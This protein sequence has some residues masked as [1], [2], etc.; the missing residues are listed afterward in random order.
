LKPLDEAERAA[1][2]E[3]SAYTLMRGDAAFMHQQVVDAL[4][5]QRG[6]P[7][8]KPIGVAFALIGLYLHLERGYTGRDVQRAHMR[9]ARKRKQWPAFDPPAE[10]GAITAVEVMQSPP[11]P[12]RDQA[13]EEWCVS[14]WEAWRDSHDRVAAMLRE[15]DE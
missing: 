9:L 7:G 11:G 2:N 13:I 5:A 12:Q 3:L 15:L 6:T 14:V 1:Q 10:R 8:S 4:A